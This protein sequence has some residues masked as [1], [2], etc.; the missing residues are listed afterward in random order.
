MTDTPKL[1]F[2]FDSVTPRMMIEFKK[3]TGTSLMSLADKQGNIDVA[4]IGEEVIT[5]FIWLSLRMSGQPDAT[6]DQ[7][8]DTPFSSLEF[9]EEDDADPTSASSAS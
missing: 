4:N 6:W 7:A 8:L 1:T 3:K 9:A 5:G 2:D